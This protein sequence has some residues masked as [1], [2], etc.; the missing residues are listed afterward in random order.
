[1]QTDVLLDELL[2]TDD[3]DKNDN[4]VA[5]MQRAMDKFHSHV[6]TMISQAAQKRQRLY[7]NQHLEN[8]KMNQLL[9]TV[10][11]QKM[12][13]VDKFIYLGALSPDQCT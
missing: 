4:S 8:R 11:G 9:F 1:M 5:K 13:V 6:I 2:C 12:K 7:T 10:N 3:M